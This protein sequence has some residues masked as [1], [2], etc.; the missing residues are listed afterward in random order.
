MRLR[1]IELQGFKSFPDRTK[2]TFD[3]GITA[4]VGPNG[5]GKSNI[6]DGVRWVFGEQS[7]K[8]L[9]GSKMEDVIFGGTQKRK[10]QGFASVSLTIDNSDRS[11]PIQENEVVV[12]RK[13]YRSGESEYKINNKVVRLRDVT[14]LFLDTG[15]SRDGYSVIG[16]GKIAEIVSAKSAQ[17]R[18][19]F[20]E[21][22]GIAKFRLRKGEAERRLA[23]AEENL[24]RLRD[25]LGELEGRVEPL[26]LQSQKAK[27]FLSL[28]G[29]KRVLEVSLW[30]RSLEELA[31]RLREQEDKILICQNDRDAIQS[32]IDR[33]DEELAQAAQE[34]QRTAVEIDQRRGQIRSLE[35]SASHAEAE[36]AVMEG[37]I[38]HSEENIRRIEGEM[39]QADLSGSQLEEKIAQLS[40]R[41]GEQE[42]ALAQAD[43]ALA[44]GAARQEETRLRLEE[45]RLQAQ[46]RRGQG[47]QL[48]RSMA[49]AELESA[50]AAALMEDAAG[51]IDQFQESF[52][53]R[54]E[55]LAQIDREQETAKGLASQLEERITSLQNARA[56]YEMK[57]QSRQH[58]QAALLQEQQ[59]YDSQGGQRLQRAQLLADME[60]NMEGMGG[61][62]KFVMGKAREG[63][64]RGIL[65]PVSTLLSTQGE[66]ATAIEVAL[67]GAMQNLVVE[68]E[69]A[70]KRA[71]ALLSQAKAGRATFLP[72]TAVKGSRMNSADA[73][74]RPGYVGVACDLVQCDDRYRGVVQWLL[75]RTVIAENL[76]LAVE[77]AKACGHKF[78]IVTL[79]G[80][81]MNAGGSMTGGY[82]A[83]SA[84]ILGRRGEIERLRRQAEEFA[85]RSRQVEEKI[86]GETKEIQ[87]LQAALEGIDGETRS[88][89]EDLLQAQSE[90]RRLEGRRRDAQELHDRAQA[91]YQQLQEKLRSLRE[92]NLTAGQL[93]E[94]LS[95][96]LARLE[97]EAAAL[98]QEQAGLAARQ[99]EERQAASALQM[100]RVSA[101]KDLEAVCQSLD[102]LVEQREG[103]SRRQEELA[104]QREEYRQGIQRTQEEIVSRRDRREKETAQAAALTAQNEAAA[105]ARLEL[106]ARTA[107]LR[108]DQRAQSDLREKTAGELA[109]L[110]ERRT[111][112]AGEQET[113][114]GQ[115]WE[116]YEM[117]PAQAKDSAVAIP[118]EGEA[119]R[120]LGELR[121]RIKGLGSVNLAAIEE[122]EEVSQRYQFMKGQMEDIET[123]KNELGQMIAGLTG[124][125]RRIFG[126]KFARINEQFGRIFVDLFGG[127]R[128]RLELTD[129]SDLLESGIEIFVQPPGKVIKNLSALS[130]GEQAFVAIAIYFAILKVSPAPFCLIDE[131]EAALDDVNVTKFASYLRRMT[132]KT[133]FIAITHRRG[134]MEE[135][136]VLYG[137]TMQEEGV[138]KVLRLDVSEIEKQLG[139]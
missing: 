49:Q 85:A 28:S 59:G 98:E 70:A 42:E 45:V 65:G 37:D 30:S 50:S 138:S 68:D 52:R 135:A 5:S 115:L 72:L 136:D 41:K 23:A 71:I 106:E 66:Y 53:L 10:A 2:L 54:D 137:V 16:Q 9:R 78:K 17:R 114:C 56:G 125:M 74:R 6:S 29:E 48:R 60:K 108:Q 47:E 38:R 63:A 22:A 34:M 122:Y 77:M 82:L 104:A 95:A 110:E 67:G 57:L 44:Q 24:V 27:E 118:D 58:R 4:I 101:Q 112:M 79:D 15:L 21:A 61:S 103:A 93:R 131:I 99:E 12:S 18:E 43:E 86:Q 89:R 36:I 13:L 25:I 109:R 26:R 97:E 130:G 80:Q 73:Q 111:T 123:S 20:E 40:A 51:R 75:G 134:T 83:K 55:T 120:R 100:E 88:A 64:L 46:A 7:S 35:E 126:E 96:Q 31:A 119:R 33:M 11:L 62:V 69:S 116:E 8:V 39:A 94:N 129:P 113:I 81:V 117:T 121:G 14:E 1:A 127:G 76:D 132:D 92:Q 139:L 87:A 19:I 133:Q 90:L 32:R 124:E 107:Q 84:G 91:E 128:A 102:L 3:D 105:A